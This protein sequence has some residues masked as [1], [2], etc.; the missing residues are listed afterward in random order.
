MQTEI[1]PDW[2]EVS[3]PAPY[4]A[5]QRLGVDPNP[6]PNLGPIPARDFL[7]IELETVLEEA[8]NAILD[9]ALR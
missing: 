2:V 3:S 9:E 7:A 1:G 8:A 6:L 4:A 5:A